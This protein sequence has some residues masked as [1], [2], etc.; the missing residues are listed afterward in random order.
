MPGPCVGGEGAF[1]FNGT[2]PIGTEFSF[3]FLKCILSGQSGI[4]LHGSLFS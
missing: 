3:R 1:E 4:E 2:V